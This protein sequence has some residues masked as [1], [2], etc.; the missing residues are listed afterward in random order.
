MKKY[1]ANEINADNQ[2]KKIKIKQDACI[3]LA[4]SASGT[5]SGFISVHHQETKEAPTRYV[6]YSF[7]EK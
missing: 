6:G 5:L 4:Y 3:R 2:L 1:V 7:E